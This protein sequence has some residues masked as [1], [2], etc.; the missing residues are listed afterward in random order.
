MAEK[1]SNDNFPGISGF[2]ILKKLGRGGMAQV[3]LAIQESMDREVAIKIML[4][5]L[6]TDPTFGDRFLREARIAAKLSHPHIVSVIDVG[7]ADDLYYMA[8]EYLPGGDLSSRIRKGMS[9]QEAIHTLKQIA[10]ALDYAHRTGFV[11]RDIKPD[12]ILFS[13]SGSAQLT[14]FGIARAADGGT[15]LTATGSIIG[16]PHYMSP[17]QA[18][19][20]SLDGRAD[21]YSL[22]VMFYQMLTGKVPFDGE[23]AMSIGIKHIRDPVPKLDNQLARYQTF[24]DKLMAKE[25]EDRWQSAGN[26]LRTLEVIEIQDNQVGASITFETPVNTQIPIT[27]V[28]PAKNNKKEKKTFLSAIVIGL[29]SIVVVVSALAWQLNW[30]ETDTAI[31]PDTASKSAE[32]PAK[33]TVSQ[34]PVVVNPEGQ[35]KKQPENTGKVVTRET[36]QV[37]TTGSESEMES[38]PEPISR[39]EPEP[40]SKQ[41]DRPSS[42]EKT[43]VKAEPKPAPITPTQPDLQEVKLLAYLSE[44]NDL[45]SPAR[46]NESR[47]EQAIRLHHSAHNITKDD[48]RVLRLQE[49]IASGYQILAEDALLQ[50]NLESASRLVG[51]GLSIMPEH[52]GLKILVARINDEAS[53]DDK[54]ESQKEES[55]PRRSFGGF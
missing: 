30:F 36:T 5:Q 15:Q 14:D 29:I 33:T 32:S 31:K 47:L 46:L 38:K 40:E 51:K 20:K 34:K 23:S 24:L 49:Q 16:T 53:S 12:N 41:S 6:L 39:V 7:V 19:G 44:A 48:R 8:M 1:N 26:V 42:T 25:P 3:Y 55:P 13:R 28:N 18:Q 22:G 27:E 35:L 52:R 21:L 2:K 37:A 17:E 9:E 11:H 45:L 50:K 4:P 10:S 43:V 54:A